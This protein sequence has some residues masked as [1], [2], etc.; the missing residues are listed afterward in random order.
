MDI[1]DYFSRINY[2]DPVGPLDIETL[3]KIFHHHIM[4]LPFENLSIH[5]G[6]TISLDINSIF[7]KVV[8]KQRGGW[9]TELNHLLF[10]VLKTIGYKV[11]MLASN[12]FQPQLGTYYCSAQH[13][14]LKVVI[15]SKVYIVD[16]GFGASSQMWQPLELISAKYQHQLP[17]TF[18]LTENNGIWY[19]DKIRRKQLTANNQFSQSD[20]VDATRY[21]KLHCFTLE[22]KTIDFFQDSCNFLQ[23][24]A[25]SVFANKS[26]CTLQVK[27][28]VRA[29]VG[30]T[31]T[32]TKYNE[33]EDVDLVE[34]ST[35]Q[36]DDIAHILKEKFGIVLESSLVVANNI[37]RFKI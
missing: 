18:L 30:W 17:G 31:Y 14:L 27:D 36:D 32:K 4:M 9:C 23:T 12:I 33:R 19:L 7:Q 21:K 35:I 1:N 2:K 15:N 5:C 28:G 29:L 25:E 26:I 10:W 11:T 3:S 6:E 34:F 37:G 24:S 20:L 8:K 16:G 22:E 13:L